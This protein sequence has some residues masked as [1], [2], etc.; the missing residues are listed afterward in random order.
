MR[1]LV[2]SIDDPYVMPF[3]VLFHSLQRTGSLEDDTPV[4]ILHE[5]TLSAASIALL[6]GFFTRYGRPVS[7]IAANGHIPD[8]LPIAA[9]D[10]VSKATFYRLF[11]AEIL[12]PH[13]A[14]VLYLDADTVAIRGIRDLLRME[15]ASPVAAADH[16]SPSDQIRLWGGKGGGYFQAGVMLFD[17]EW[18]RVN[19]CAELFVDILKTQ[20]QRI[21]WWDQDVLNIAFENKWQRLDVCYN[22]CQGVIRAVPEDLLKESA[23]LIHYDGSHKPWVQTVSRPFKDVWLDA[24]ESAFAAR[25][26]QPLP[27]PGLPG[28]LANAVLSR[29]KG[30]IHGV[31]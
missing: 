24:Y 10:H 16:L 29:V 9:G 17:L 26:E 8:D 25:H 15:L 23:R 14:S 30:L 6:D 3:Q 20:R 5:E 31:R 7:F 1:A 19:R 12:P 13:I 4:F 2:F 22:V 11:V 21:L 27:S 18:W 28:I